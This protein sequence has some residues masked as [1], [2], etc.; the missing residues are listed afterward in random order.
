MPQGKP[1]GSF[2]WLKRLTVVLLIAYFL[3]EVVARSPGDSLTGKILL[4]WAFL[5]GLVMWWFF[6]K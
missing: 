2:V 4:I 5:V 3:G 6:R 1:A